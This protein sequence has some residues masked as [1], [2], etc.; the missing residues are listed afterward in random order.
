MTAFAPAREDGRSD[1]VV[2]FEFAQDFEP[3]TLFAFDTLAH[4][5]QNGLNIEVTRQR[6]SQAVQQANK[7]LLREKSRYLASVRGVGYRMI[8]ADE[9]VSKALER[10]TKAEQQIK[11][12]LDI[13]R[14]TRTDELDEAQRALHTGQLLILDG[15]YRM[16]KASEERHKQTE[17]VLNQIKEK[18]ATIDD[19]LTNI[20]SKVAQPAA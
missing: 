3:D 20:E 1:R 13:L 5:L 8:R 19:R 12:G 4:E 17:Q 18:Q 7:T 15:V 6:I 2:I 10:K 11:A 9:H 14:N 16:A